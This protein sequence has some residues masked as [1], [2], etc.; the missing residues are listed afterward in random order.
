PLCSFLS[1]PHLLY[2]CAGTASVLS[3]YF[4]SWAHICSVLQNPSDTAI[5]APTSGPGPAGP[6]TKQAGVLAYYKVSA[7]VLDS[8]A[9]QA[10]DAPQDVPCAYKDNEWVGYDNIKSSNIKVRWDVCYG[11]ALDLDDFT[12]TFCKEGKYPLITSLKKGLGMQKGKCVP[13]TQ[14]SPP[15]T[16]PPCTTGGI[17]SGSGGSGVSDFCAGKANGIYVDPANK[18]IVYNC[19]NGKTFV[20]SCDDSLIFDISSSCCNWP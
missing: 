14:P 5:G 3:C 16:E 9:T 10:W 7:N 20:Q 1:R 12:G 4:T 15:A 11:W 2:F 8:G 6:Y 13:P 17:G 18:S 19:I